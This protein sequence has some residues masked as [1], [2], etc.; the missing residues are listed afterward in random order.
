MNQEFDEQEF[1]RRLMDGDPNSEELLVF[2]Q[3]VLDRTKKRRKEA[4]HR[5]V[6]E[7]ND[8]LISLRRRLEELHGVT[9]SLTHPGAAVVVELAQINLDTKVCLAELG[10]LC[11][12]VPGLHDIML[13]A[14]A[15]QYNAEDQAAARESDA[16]STSRSR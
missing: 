1:L 12:M 6:I 2:A 5:R 9:G 14:L 16:E 15:D 10:R 11:A 13:D 8:E 4:A 7:I 3:T